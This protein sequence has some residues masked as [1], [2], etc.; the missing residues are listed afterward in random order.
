[1]Q[2]RMHRDGTPL[3]Y[4][5]E[6]N[7]RTCAVRNHISFKSG[8]KLTWKCAILLK[9]DRKHIVLTTCFKRSVLIEMD[10]GRDKGQVK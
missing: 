7:L 9:K 4:S 8:F 3:R 2:F 10:R 6:K 5:I 1:M